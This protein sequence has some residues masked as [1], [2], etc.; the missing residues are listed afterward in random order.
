MGGL[1]FDFTTGWPRSDVVVG[2]TS[3]TVRCSN[4]DANC[5]TIGGRTSLPVGL[6]TKDIRESFLRVKEQTFLS[7]FVLFSNQHTKRKEEKEKVWE[8]RRQRNSSSKFLASLL[9]LYLSFL[10]PKKGASV[11]ESYLGLPASQPSRVRK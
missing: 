9:F 3:F 6:F 7:S 8:R 10:Q 2:Y 11:Q 4:V 1:V 5:L